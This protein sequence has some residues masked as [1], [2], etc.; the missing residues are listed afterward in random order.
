MHHNYPTFHI[1]GFHRAITVCV[2]FLLTTVHADPAVVKLKW[3][4]NPEQDI[5]GYRVHKGPS[6]GNY[7]ETL[8]VGPTT[9]A[10]I[11]NL[12]SGTEYFFAV[13]AYNT[14]GLESDP[15]AELS[16]IPLNEPPSVSLTSPT[17]EETF[18]APAA[19]TLSA[20]ATDNDGSI[21]HYSKS[22]GGPWFHSYSMNYKSRFSEPVYKQRCIVFLSY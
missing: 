6:S 4:P 9:T 17:S 18:T 22:G 20:N 1:F 8:D 12:S 13:T 2:L 16:H 10:T 21:S 14:S 3:D 19:I 11:E 5:A 7:I 15:S